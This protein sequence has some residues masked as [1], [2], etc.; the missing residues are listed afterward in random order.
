M[1]M[2]VEKAREFGIGWVGVRNVNSL[3]SARHYALMAAAQR[4]VG[5]CLTNGCPLLVP[6]GGLKVKTGTNPIAI[7]APA[8][9][10]SPVVPGYGL[11]AVGLRAGARLRQP[12]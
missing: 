12:G 7:A 2:A 4:M 11:C 1:N 9:R 6:P 5:I 10:C 8:K 3:G